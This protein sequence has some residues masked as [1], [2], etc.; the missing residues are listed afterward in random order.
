MLQRLPSF[1]FARIPPETQ[2]NPPPGLGATA[3]GR[4]WAGDVLV[5][6]FWEAGKDEELVLDEQ[7]AAV[8]E[9]GANSFLSNV[10]Q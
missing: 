4:S 2:R 7:Q 10:L 6:P 8:D 5:L 3:F 1:G 9:A